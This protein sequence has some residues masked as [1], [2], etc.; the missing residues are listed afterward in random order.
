MIHTEEIKYLSLLFFLLHPAI[1]PEICLLINEEGAKLNAIYFSALFLSAHFS[2][3]V[4]S[5]GFISLLQ[6]AT[7]FGVCL[8]WRSFCADVKLAE[9][10]TTVIT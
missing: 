2:K 3:L 5:F 6:A 8:V 10:S 1:Y 7:G 4:S 9:Q